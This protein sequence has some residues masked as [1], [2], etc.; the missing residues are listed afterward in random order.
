MTTSK[1][2]NTKTKYNALL[3]AYKDLDIK[4]ESKLVKYFIKT[5]EN[6]KDFIKKFSG[7]TRN[8]LDL[9]YRIYL[10]ENWFKDDIFKKIKEGYAL[11]IVEIPKSYGNS[12]K[13]FLEK[14]DKEFG[15][16]ISIV[17]TIK[18]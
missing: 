14:L 12:I 8:S 10:Y 4:T 17:K 5:I 13:N 9:S 2:Q 18:I 11:G 16:K 1:K 15:N 3:I 6:E 7:N